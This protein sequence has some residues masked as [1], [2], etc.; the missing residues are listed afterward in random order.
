MLVFLVRENR[1]EWSNSEP[2]DA[3]DTNAEY[4]RC[5][6]KSYEQDRSKCQL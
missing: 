2:S 1:M 4:S 5:D 3:D 6:D